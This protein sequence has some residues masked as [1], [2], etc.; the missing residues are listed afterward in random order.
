MKRR[1]AVILT[2]SILMALALAIQATS[3]ASASGV[4]PQWVALAN[5]PHA[6]EGGCT[7]LFHDKIYVAYGFSP[8]LGDTNSLRVYDI[9]T[10]TWSSGPVAPGVPRS[11]GYRGVEHDGRI[12]CIGGRSS[13]RVLSDLVRF[14]PSTNMWKTL[15][16]MPVALA[17]MTA[18][19]AGENLY[20]FGGRTTT[21]PCSGGTTNTILRYNFRTNTWSVAGHLAISRSDATAA[22]VG[23]KIYIFGG[24]NG[25]T[26]AFFDSVEVFNPSRGTS[27]L[28]AAT[29]PGGPRADAAATVDDFTIHIVGG[30]NRSG[31]IGANNHLLFKTRTKTFSIGVMMPRH[32]LGAA[33]RAELELVIDEERIYA[34]AGSCPAFGRSIPNLDSLQV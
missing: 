12:Y 28:L 22:R 17:G 19:T 31:T 33:D 13:G 34:V 5:L 23:N 14:D 26:G 4:P 10:N 16:P 7:A 30:W 2:V 21:A 27:T 29:M 11:E 9:R 15:A 3:I 6:T 1:R 32:C 20:T 18:V 25:N 8:G 24:C